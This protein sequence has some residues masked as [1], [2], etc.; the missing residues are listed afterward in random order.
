MG[1]KRRGTRGGKVEKQ[2]LGEKRGKGSVCVWDLTCGA[3]G[4]I[5]VNN[6][7]GVTCGKWPGEEVEKEEGEW[8]KFFCG[9]RSCA[10]LGVDAE[11]GKAKKGG[12]KVRKLDP[13]NGRKRG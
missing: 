7:E 2:Q 12:A 4:G 10:G 8:G 11:K 3:G 13:K 9:S 1:E 6:K 5:S